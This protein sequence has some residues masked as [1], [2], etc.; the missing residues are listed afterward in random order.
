MQDN[1]SQNVPDLQLSSGLQAGHYIVSERA[2][3]CQDNNGY[4]VSNSNKNMNKPI[5]VQNA[6]NNVLQSEYLMNPLALTSPM[7]HS[8]QSMF[9]NIGGSQI[10]RMSQHVERR[11]I[12]PNSSAVP[13][14]DCPKTYPKC[15]G[16]QNGQISSMAASFYE[17]SSD[18]DQS[19][20]MQ[21]SVNTNMNPNIDTETDLNINLPT[22]VSGQRGGILR[23]V[24]ELHPRC[25]P[26][27]TAFPYF[28]IVQ[29]TVFDT[30]YGTDHSLVVSAPT[31]SGKT[32]I[33]EL[34]IVRQAMHIIDGSVGNNSSTT[35]L[36]NSNKIIYIAPMKALVSERYLD[37]K[38]RLTQVLGLECVEVTGDTEEYSNLPTAQVRHDD[39]CPRTMYFDDYF[40]LVS[41]VFEFC[42]LFLKHKSLSVTYNL[43]FQN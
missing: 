28:N 10:T 18:R 43:F 19:N 24:N 11:N 23:S 27:F 35:D 38:V 3:Y 12:L 39:D 30:V 16:I 5:P 34:A 36:K 4:N 17:E 32:V 25:R 2:A 37:W 41:D 42:F 21:T 14:F 40:R 22:N 9:N 8:S 7:D 31:G 20:I 1:A 15:G 29:S 33:L 6:I 13:N 26:L